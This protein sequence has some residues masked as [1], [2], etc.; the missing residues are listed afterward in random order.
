MDSIIALDDSSFDLPIDLDSPY[1]DIYPEFPE[2]PIDQLIER[3]NLQMTAAISKIETSSATVL[4]TL[5][6]RAMEAAI[7]RETPIDVMNA[8]D[9]DVIFVGEENTVIN[10][11]SPDKG[12]STSRL[13]PNQNNDKAT[14]TAAT[15][16]VPQSDSMTN[17]V[18]CAVCMES[19]VGREPH[20][21]K[22]GHIF[23]GAC[24]KE[25]IKI[26]RKCPLCNKFLTVKNL[27][28]VFI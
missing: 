21:T 25:A 16:T 18:M 17:S 11:C 4:S 19:S 2:E 5:T 27:M 9:D 24:I 23:C 12:P 22:C 6:I 28:P 1:A 14:V 8:T 7:E 13:F 20:S 3:A 15:K 10:L 26:T